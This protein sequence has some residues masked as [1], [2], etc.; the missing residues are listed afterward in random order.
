MEYD[1]REG[2]IRKYLNTLLP[3]NWETM[4][5]YERRAYLSDRDSG[6]VAKGTVKRVAVCNMEIWCECFGKD[7][8]T[9]RRSD[10]YAIAAI[11]HKQDNWKKSERT[12]FPIYGQQRTYVRDKNE[13]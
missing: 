1:D 10:S 13:N 8:S 3:E 5:L 12:S 6:M 4:D 9:I 11:M 2:L 7:P